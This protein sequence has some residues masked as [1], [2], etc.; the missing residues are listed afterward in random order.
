ML[1]RDM[2]KTA[3]VNQHMGIR[4]DKTSTIVSGYVCA[5]LHIDT[6]IDANHHAQT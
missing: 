5:C 6:K 2:Q 3:N 4:C 1:G